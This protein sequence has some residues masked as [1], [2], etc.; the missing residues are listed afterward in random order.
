MIRFERSRQF[1]RHK[2][3][4]AVQY[5]KDAATLAGTIDANARFQVFTGVFGSV[6]RVFW[7]VDFKGL[8]ALEK[9]LMKIE[10]DPRWKDFIEDAP[11]DIFVDGTGH[12]SIMEP[13]D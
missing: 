6:E 10:S 1:K 8:A 9:T 2:K 12:D 5:A 7:V 11:E 4:E 3:S 13:V